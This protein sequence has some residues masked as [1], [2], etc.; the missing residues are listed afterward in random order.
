VLIA[1]AGVD[2]PLSAESREL[3]REHGQVL[4]SYTIGLE[5]MRTLT[6]GTLHHKELVTDELVNLRHEMS[7][8]A[9]K[10]RDAHP[11]REQSGPREAPLTP[12][13]LRAGYHRETLILW[14]KDDHGN[15]IERGYR[16]FEAMPGAELHCFD[17]CGHWPMWDQTEAFVSV[18]SAFLNRA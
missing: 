14:G 5:N 11:A 3:S 9:Q 10:G 4:S 13:E 6:L 7:L 1:G 17:E 18:V 16:M 12:E 8:A 15:P 2:V